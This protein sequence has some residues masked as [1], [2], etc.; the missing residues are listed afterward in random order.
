M[1]HVIRSVDLMR[2]LSKRVLH[3][4]VE[5]AHGDSGYGHAG[6]SVTA[7]FLV[8]LERAKHWFSFRT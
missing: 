6:S 7:G 3:V 1:W 4:F 5:Y 8:I 2:L